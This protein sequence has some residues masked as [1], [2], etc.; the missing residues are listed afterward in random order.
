MTDMDASGR[1][2]HAAVVCGKNIKH[3]LNLSFPL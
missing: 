1:G 3:S 2:G